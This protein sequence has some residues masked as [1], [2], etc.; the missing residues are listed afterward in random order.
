[1]AAERLIVRSSQFKRDFKLARKRVD[2]SV[3]SELRIVLKLLVA[4]DSLP[5]RYRDHRLVG[6]SPPVRECHIRPDLLLIYRLLE[7][8]LELVRLGSHSDL[9]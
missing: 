7:D 4:G 2:D 1:L 5:Q 9:F 6:W 3:D 8:R